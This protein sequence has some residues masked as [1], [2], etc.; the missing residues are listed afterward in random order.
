M[1]I[2]KSAGKAAVLLF[3][4]MV[5]W[6][7]FSAIWGGGMLTGDPVVREWIGRSSPWMIWAI[8]V[9]P[10]ILDALQR[11]IKLSR[12]QR[13]GLALI[14]IA[15]PYQAALRVF[16]PENLSPGGP[17]FVSVSGF[18][19]NWGLGGILVGIGLALLA[20]RL[21]RPPQTEEA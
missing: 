11:R 6:G 5:L 9:T 14:L 20:E 1:W 4:S 15:A 16:R 8:L 17:S 13:V 12:I 19:W 7:L 18:H 10:P 21:T 2:L 3:A